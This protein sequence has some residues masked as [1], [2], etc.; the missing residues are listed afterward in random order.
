MPRPAWL[1]DAEIH[2]WRSEAARR[3]GDRGEA[4]AA[5]SE[6]IAAT[7]RDHVAAWILRA[8]AAAGPGYPGATLDPGAWRPI[9]DRLG[10]R[11]GDVGT[12]TRRGEVLPALAA[13]L[14]GFGGNRSATLTVP[15]AHAPAGLRAWRPAPFPRLEA[16]RLQHL[17]RV[18]PAA[19]VLAAFD[20]LAAR[21][22]GDPTPRTYQ[23]EV[24]LWLGR[25]PEAA[26]AFHDALALDRETVWAWIGLGA[27]TLYAGDPA[28]AL[29]T[30]AEGVAAVGFEGPTLFPYRAEAR[31]A[32]GDR[33]GALA[34]LDHALATKPDRPSSWMTRALMRGSRR[35]ARD[36]AAIVRAGAPGLWVDAA[37][38]ADADPADLR[39]APEVFPQALRLCRGNRSSTLLT[40][41]PAEAAPARVHVWPAGRFE[42]LREP[43]R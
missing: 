11:L 25:W 15:D 33:D 27:A 40:W 37:Q 20:A 16:R 2:A 26:A 9:A 29:A 4:V 43:E 24:L 23:G 21:F 12:G 34:D 13:A 35:H 36:V 28:A 10:E 31:W 8:L 3:A 39:A 7:P 41:I 32:L 22:P 30:W 18:R 38:L 14:A 1:T 19:D 17:L 5:A 42:A 6:A